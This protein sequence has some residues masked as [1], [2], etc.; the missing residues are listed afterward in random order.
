MLP[1]R[2]VSGYLCSGCRKVFASSSVGKDMRLWKKAVTHGNF[3]RNCKGM[4]KFSLDIPFRASDAMVG[5]SG[6]ARIVDGK[7]F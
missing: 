1:V 7:V 4:E 5:G 6:S 2:R 3:S